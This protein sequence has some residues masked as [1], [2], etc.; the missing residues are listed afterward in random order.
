MCMGKSKSNNTQTTPQPAQPTSFQYVNADTSNS[1]QRQAAVNS[2][3]NQSA[4]SS[5]GSELGSSSMTSQSA[6]GP[7]VA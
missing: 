4:S 7:G 5:F 2:T 1:Q 6:T 3:T